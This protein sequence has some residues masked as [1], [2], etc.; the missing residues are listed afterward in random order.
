MAEM[1]EGWTEPARRSKVVTRT[2]VREVLPLER[3][4]YNVFIESTSLQV[5]F[6][7]F[8]CFWNNIYP[9]EIMLYIYI[10]K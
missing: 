10:F 8:M 1:I 2:R 7:F 5:V 3:R 6:S 9:K 4:R